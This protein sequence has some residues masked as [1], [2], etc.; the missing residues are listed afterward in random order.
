MDQ[1]CIYAKS[2][3]KKKGEIEGK[4]N[5]YLFSLLFYLSHMWIDFLGWVGP[6]VD[7]TLNGKNWKLKDILGLF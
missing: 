3:R 5:K 2:K 4:I 7:G 1:K 6:H